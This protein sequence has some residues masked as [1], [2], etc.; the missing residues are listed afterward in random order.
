MAL[1]V[2]ELNYDI[3][4][5]IIQTGINVQIAHFKRD[6]CF[7]TNLNNVVLTFVF[8]QINMLQ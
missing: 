3:E 5:T 7:K 2:D 4:I 8:Q 6:T 1:T